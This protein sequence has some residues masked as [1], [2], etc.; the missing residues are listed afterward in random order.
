M[1]LV[2]CKVTALAESD[3]D[4]TDG[5]NIVAGA[6]V[7][8]Y[9]T[10]GAVATLYDDRNGNGG[11]T[12]KTTDSQGVVV[13]YV[14]PGEYDTQINNGKRRRIAVGS[15]AVTEDV[16]IAI[17]NI[18]KILPA[19]TYATE[20]ELLAD[21]T[22]ENNA[23]A[24]VRENDTFY[25]KNGV[26]GTGSWYVAPYT[27]TTVLEDNHKRPN[28]WHDPFFQSVRSTT[29][30]VDGKQIFYYSSGSY[31][32]AQEDAMAKNRH[33]GGAWKNETG[34]LGFQIW[35][36]IEGNAQFDIAENDIVSFACILKVASG[37]TGRFFL[38][39][40][41]EN[42][43][44]TAAQVVSDTYVSDG[45]ERVLK[46]DNQSVPAN[47]AFALIFFD[48]TSTTNYI[49]GLWGSVG[50][51]AGNSPSNTTYVQSAEVVDYGTPSLWADPYFREIR[52]ATDDIGG[53][54]VVSSIYTNGEY[55]S[56]GLDA[57][58]KNDK[59]GGAW[60]IGAG[61]ALFAFNFTFDN[62]SIAA[63]GIT[64]GDVLSVGCKMKASA[65]SR[66][67]FFVRYV[68]GTGT[69][70]SPQYS[71][72]PTGTGE[73][74]TLKLENLAVPALAAGALLYFDAGAGG[75]SYLS[76]LW[77]VQGATAG[78][79]A[80]ILTV[81]VSSQSASTTLN[82]DPE[83]M[84]LGTRV[85]ALEGLQANVYPINLRAGRGE[86][87][88]DFT[89]TG[90]KGLHLNE[91]WTWTP[92]A[93]DAGDYSFVASNLDPDTLAV[94]ADATAM[95]SVLAQGAVSGATIRYMAIGD[96]T[97]ASNYR[98]QRVADLSTARTTDAQ[99]TLVGTEGVAPILHEGRNGWTVQRY[100]QPDSI[101][102]ADNPFVENNGDK[103]SAAYYV[104]NSGQPVPEVISWTLGINDVF[105]AT[106]DTDLQ[107]RMDVFLSQLSQMIGNEAA[108]DVTSWKEVDNTIVHLV[109]LP[110]LPLDQ[111]G[112]STV[113]GSGQSQ[114]RYWRNIVGASLRIID[115]FKDLESEKIFL[116]P[117]NASIDIFH[118][119]ER[120]AAEPWNVHTTDTVERDSND[121]HP[122]GAG[123]NEQLGDCEYAALNW[124][125]ANG[126]I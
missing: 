63:F 119:M 55:V 112:F 71:L 33:S 34:I 75:D 68:D 15:S 39:F 26:S 80:P 103:F 81:P 92:L 78:D 47:T 10:T 91:R 62:P 16:R 79:S 97:T 64:E 113:T 42:G 93:A 56:G 76:E 1:D 110:I 4:G 65:S 89:V 25:A 18:E 6:V 9:D 96:S 48:A 59:A 58:A 20:A 36:D 122:R 117:F 32:T 88:F 114:A 101:Y 118:N 74:V 72:T 67:G 87:I 22:P 35:F 61:G 14:Y 13:F 29:D 86:R 69:F 99:I 85:F 30:T 84:A 116:M 107:S 60:R 106:S 40:F 124:L 19:L 37:Q 51:T 3:A 41:D 90:D 54:L 70:V 57:D 121:V 52:S 126:H 83:A 125:K 50:V 8:L 11:S 12:A 43:D 73:F 17:D 2:P 21:L 24:W 100:Y 31:V 77:V 104:A 5:K 108:A 102:V 95:L 111:D 44:P 46:I 120:S 53:E 94:K 109:S 49:M 45:S 98:V 115:H 27:R 38:R 82:P 7:V 123:G 23:L 105:S 66:T 28:L